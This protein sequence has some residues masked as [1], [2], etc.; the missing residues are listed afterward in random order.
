ML[1]ETTPPN[2][3]LAHLV[4]ISTEGVRSHEAI[5][6]IRNVLGGEALDSL[7]LAWSVNSISPLVLTHIMVTNSGT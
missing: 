3:V 2:P 5:S 6:Q 7:D 1:H 4:Q